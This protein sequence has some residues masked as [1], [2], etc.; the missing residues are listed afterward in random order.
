MSGHKNDHKDY[1]ERIKIHMSQVFSVISQ[2][3]EQGNTSPK[4]LNDNVQIIHQGVGP[5]AGE[6]RRLA[7]KPESPPYEKQTNIDKH[8]IMIIEDE[9][10]A[11]PKSKRPNKDL[12]MA[13]SKQN[14]RNSTLLNKNEKQIVEER[15]VV[16][17]TQTQR[18]QN[19]LQESPSVQ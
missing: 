2:D 9:A 8:N 14:L 10:D 6:Q 7:S 17:R 15:K 1:N 3:Q 4:S 5:P 16:H 19:Q 13:S 18:L 12:T 11:T